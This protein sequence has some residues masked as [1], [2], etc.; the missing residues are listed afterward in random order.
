[1][2]IYVLIVIILAIIVI[3]CIISDR[4]NQE[5]R[6]IKELEKINMREERKEI[7][8]ELSIIEQELKERM[9]EYDSE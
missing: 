3:G 7:E 6:K 1:M 5:E 8:K 4:V 9:K 2:N